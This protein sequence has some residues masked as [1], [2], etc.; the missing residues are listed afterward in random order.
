MLFEAFALPHQGPLE[1]HSALL[2][3]L[4]VLGRKLIDPAQLTVAVLAADVSHHVSAGE[5]HPVLHLAVLEV[6]HL[7][8]AGQDSQRSETHSQISH[9][10]T[11]H[12]LPPHTFTCPPQEHAR[13]PSLTLAPTPPM[14]KR[15]KHPIRRPITNDLSHHHT[16]PTH[17][18]RTQSTY[19]PTLPTRAPHSHNNPKPHSH[20]DSI[21]IHPHHP[22]LRSQCGQ[23]LIYEY[24]GVSLARSTGHCAGGL[25]WV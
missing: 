15:T 16:A 20:T 13:P 11:T 24:R 9:A 14:H 23:P 1:D 3:A 5:H 10:D 18:P 25:W 8:R 17:H 2:V 7:A 22:T 12:T 4:A 6:H 21:P 19:A